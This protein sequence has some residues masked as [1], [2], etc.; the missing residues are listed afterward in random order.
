M[1]ILGKVWKFPSSNLAPTR[2]VT[3]MLCLPQAVT[4]ILGDR[5]G[6]LVTSAVEQVMQAMHAPVYFERYEVH[7]QRTLKASTLASN[8]RSS[9]ESLRALRKKVTAMH[10]TNIFL[11]PS[12]SNLMPWQCRP[13]HAVFE[14][15]A[16]AGN[17]GNE[18]LLV[19]KKANPVALLLSSAM[20]LRVETSA[21]SPIC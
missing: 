5:I 1:A 13:D 4:L 19:Q 11:E 9:L 14:Q 7:G 17:V 18:K 6:L 3:Y 15:E 12:L 20:M 8:T 10:K 2:S 16:S 21:V